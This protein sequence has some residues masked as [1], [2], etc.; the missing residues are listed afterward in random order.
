MRQRF[1]D[2]RMRWF[3]GD[4][5]DQQRL[6]QAMRNVQVVVHAAAMK[7]IETCEEQPEEAIRT[8][9]LGTLNVAKAAIGAGVEQAVALS[10]DKAPQ[11]AT[12]YGA[13]KFCAER[14]WCQSNV[15]A[16]GTP[17]R[18][19]AVRYGN[20]LGS[21][22]SVLDIF[23][24]QK[25][26]GQPIRVTSEHAT[27]FWMR[28]E[29]AVD[30]VLIA[31]THMVGGD[32]FIPKIGSASVLDLARAVVGP[33]LYAP[34][35]VETGLR[36]AE[37]LHEVLFSTDEAPRTYEAGTFYVIEPEG[38]SWGDVAPLRY[39]KVSTGFEYRSDTNAQQ[40]SVEQLRE[41]IAA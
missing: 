3:I 2:D 38:R 9:V 21:R 25:A 35:H 34:G 12:L 27:R 15:L 22:G 33:E 20:V 30:L 8:N 40:L 4:V 10:T 41:L 5:R 28:I 18:L 6:E 24:Q 17:T 39:P 1:P 7:R 36:G 23:R 14:L 32:T 19:S 11:A 37:K 31:L 29:D 13:T 26:L 16:A